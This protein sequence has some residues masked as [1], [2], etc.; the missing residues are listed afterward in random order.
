MDLCLY[1]ESDMYKLVKT[2][3]QLMQTF[4]DGLYCVCTGEFIISAA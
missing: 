2:V 1:N 4:L 3:Y